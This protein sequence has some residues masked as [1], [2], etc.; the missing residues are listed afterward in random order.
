MPYI[1][2]NA[3]TLVILI[4]VF[5]GILVRLVGLGTHPFS[6][7]E[8][9]LFKSINLI[10][11][12][13][14]PEFLCG[15]YYVR[16]ILLQYIIL[17]FVSLIDDQ[18]LAARLPIVLFS[19]LTLPA[20]YLIGRDLG[21][22]YIGVLALLLFSFSV[23]QIEFARFARMYVPFQMLFVWQVWLFINP[24]KPS[25]NINI[26]ING[27]VASIAILFYEGG[28]F[29][30]AL[31]F[32][33]LLTY[34]N[35][36]KVIFYLP[37]FIATI[38]SG[39]MI[40]IP[41]RHLGTS[42]QYSQAGSIQSTSYP[43]VLENLP[44][45]L[46]VYLV[47]ENFS[48]LL[49]FA[50]TIYLIITSLFLFKCSYRS[51]YTLLTK[52]ILFT[53]AISLLVN[54]FFLAASVLTIALLLP[55]SRSNIIELSSN[56]LAQ[57]Y[58]VISIFWGII[59]VTNFII[60]SDIHSFLTITKE[61]FNNFFSYPDIFFDIFKQWQKPM[62][63]HSTFSVICIFFAIIWCLFKQ[64]YTKNKM[65]YLLSVL[66]ST[67]LLIAIINTQYNTSRYSFFISP[68]IL[69]IISYC[70][71]TIAK[72]LS[73][74]TKIFQLAICSLSSIFIYF[75]EDFNLSHLINIDSYESNHRINY[76]I[77][78]AEHLY[79]RYDY[80]SIANY[81]NKNAAP[82]DVVVISTPTLEMYIKDNVN[83]NYFMTREN[84][85]F[86]SHSSCEGTRE[87][88]SRKPLID[89]YKDLYKTLNQETHTKW[90]ILHGKR[91]NPYTTKKHEILKEK[92][93]PFQ[94]YAN[95]DRT[96]VL[97]RIGPER[98]DFK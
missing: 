60:A 41:F 39:L 17:P 65:H 34:K 91:G 58:L 55:I 20:V 12:K 79:P 38:L 26:L 14:L 9:Y 73:K 27:V 19:I 29:C 61:I 15:G 16:G 92:V 94:T 71:F 50:F 88:W 77:Q 31:A 82:D 6:I 64:D 18:E 8:Y 68:L 66:I 47:Y 57:S 36:T 84:N 35:S 23:W 48:G 33:N 83:I 69:I 3:L 87:L 32:I 1:Q 86:I 43:D 89:N 10:I 21:S 78:Y 46:P 44:I 72:L 24:E 45:D 53:I 63:L 4:I 52:L 76:T 67:T 25:R 7:D 54:Q 85:E 5:T 56:S 62:P 90:L 49:L 93:Q 37:T 95:E 81:I 75:S 70:I 40:A 42:N 74:N 2:K 98:E 28:I 80:Y 13:G 97:Y 51:G 30:V 59:C 11:E 22:R 96:L